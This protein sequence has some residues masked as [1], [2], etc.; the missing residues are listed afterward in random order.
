MR[1]FKV[2]K[3]V[4]VGSGEN[5]PGD[6]D[7]VVP[8]ADVPTVEVSKHDEDLQSPHVENTF[9]MKEWTPW[10]WCLNHGTPSFSRRP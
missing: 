5:R 8:L 1:N 2:W 6:G 9:S 7:G 4:P 3:V 10:G